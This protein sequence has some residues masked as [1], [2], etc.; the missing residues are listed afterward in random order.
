MRRLRRLFRRKNFPV[1]YL[2]T[3]VQSMT[4]KRNAKETKRSCTVGYKGAKPRAVKGNKKK[5]LPTQ[6]PNMIQACPKENDKTIKRRRGQCSAVRGS[7]RQC[8]AT[9]TEQ[10]TLQDP[11]ADAVFR[12]QQM[13]S[14]TTQSASRPETKSSPNKK[15]RVPRYKIHPKKRQARSEVRG[16]AVLVRVGR[17]PRGAFR[18]L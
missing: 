10:T 18:S 9:L 12:K 4:T 13:C 16:G 15:N 3:V 8:A 17:W 6:R 1:A 2:F 7:A 5:E 11:S 14:Q